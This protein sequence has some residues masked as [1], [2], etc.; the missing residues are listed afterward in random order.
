MAPQC[1]I[2]GQTS[3][4]VLFLLLIVITSTI[5]IIGLYSQTSDGT[6]GISIVRTEI[7]KLAS[8]MDDLVL[9]KKVSLNRMANGANVF[10]IVTDPKTIRRDDFGQ[11]KLN[12]ISAKV[13]ESTRLTNIDYNIN[14]FV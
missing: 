10:V 5:F 6:V 12:E 8:S 7:S 4:E 14:S 13:I 3:V 9:I 1:N 11:T 2:K